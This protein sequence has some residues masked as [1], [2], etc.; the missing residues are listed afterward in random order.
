MWLFPSKQQSKKAETDKKKGGF[1]FV[2]TA[3]KHTEKK[4]TKE[5]AETPISTSTEEE[6]TPQLQKTSKQ[7]WLLPWLVVFLCP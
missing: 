3:N 7:P 2:P 6:N 1:L 4:P 5:K